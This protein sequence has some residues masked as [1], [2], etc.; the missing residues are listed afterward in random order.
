MN[1]TPGTTVTF[2]L[3]GEEVTGTWRRLADFCEDFE[4]F[5]G[6]RT[7]T[8]KRPTFVV[9]G[10]EAGR[11]WLDEHSVVGVREVRCLNDKTFMEVDMT[12]GSEWSGNWSRMRFLTLDAVAC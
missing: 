5:T 2:E 8:L 7:V 4:D 9:K 10:P 3:A 11:T 6:A 12:D 1:T